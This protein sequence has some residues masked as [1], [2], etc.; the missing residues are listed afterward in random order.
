MKLSRIII[1]V[2]ILLSSSLFWLLIK[3]QRANR[4]LQ[5]SYLEL[6][7]TLS[8]YKGR[9]YYDWRFDWIET[10]IVPMSTEITLKDTFD[11][12]VYMA[13]FNGTP[14]F[15][16]EAILLL[17]EGFDEENNLIGKIDTLPVKNWLGRIQLIPKTIGMQRYYGEFLIPRQDKYDS[18]G[19][20]GEYNVIETGN[21]E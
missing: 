5:T 16:K 6:N 13:G 11:A 4:L 19:F 9:F 20:W 1:I 21:E 10:K 18:Y 2:L 12:E 7:D 15:T 14:E 8:V 3:E 17:G